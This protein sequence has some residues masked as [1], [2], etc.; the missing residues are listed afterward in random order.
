MKIGWRQAALRRVILDM[1][2][3]FFKMSLDGDLMLQV[4]TDI[5]VWVKPAIPISL[6]HVPTGS[7]ILY[8]KFGSLIAMSIPMVMVVGKMRI[9]TGKARGHGKIKAITRRLDINNHG[10]LRYGYY[11]WVHGTPGG[12]SS[13]TIEPW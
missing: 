5:T 7:R 2:I 9:A 1:L 6:A 12:R 13:R 10:Q 4:Q 3:L 11:F 8:A